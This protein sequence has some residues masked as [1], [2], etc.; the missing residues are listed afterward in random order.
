MSGYTHQNAGLKIAEP[1]LP[2]PLRLTLGKI[3][4][5][6]DNRLTPPATTSRPQVRQLTKIAHFAPYAQS[7]VPLPRTA[8]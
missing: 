1:Y 2:K 4:T 7:W 6:L 3:Q 5:V 8:K